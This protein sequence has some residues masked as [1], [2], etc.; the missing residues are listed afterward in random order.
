V[1][2]V[3]SQRRTFFTLQAAEKVL[4]GGSPLDLEKLFEQMHPRP[5]FKLVQEESWQ[6]YSPPEWLIAYSDN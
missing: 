1:A 5:A 3:R 6:S 2:S 4:E